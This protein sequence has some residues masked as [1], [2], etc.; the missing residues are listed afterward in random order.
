[1]PTDDSYFYV[2]IE[3]RRLN[4]M[5]TEGADAFIHDGT[6]PYHS[7]NI[8]QCITPA[9]AT[10]VVDQSSSRNETTTTSQRRQATEQLTQNYIMY[11]CLANSASTQVFERIPA[12]ELECLANHACNVFT[13]LTNNR[14]WIK[15]GV[16]QKVDKELLDCLIPHMKHLNFVTVA[17]V[18]ST[19]LLGVIADLCAAKTP[20]MPCPDFCDSILSITNNARLT[21]M[22]AGW[23]KERTFKKLE[24]TGILGQAIRCITCTQPS[25]PQD[26]I[27]GHLFILE[28][29][30]E[31]PMLIQEKFQKGT[32]SGDILNNVL[33]GKDGY[34]GGA[35]RHELVMARL[36]NI[37]KIAN[38][39]SHPP[40]QDALLVGLMCRKCNKN[41][42]EAEFQN[43][44]LVCG[45][46]KQT[47][48]CSK[49][50]KPKKNKVQNSRVK[51]SRLL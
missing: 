14:K 35:R 36:A 23:K 26:A 2:N 12:T 37:Q 29:L 46:C 49:G 41:S 15:T 22:I 27:Q 25:L 18:P 1:M 44:L 47:Y 3:G 6:R 30:M 10:L 28:V 16:L 13:Q 38:V 39:T 51:I 20:G 42:M 45:R 19:N 7:S 48:Y 50:K 17:L 5:T 21:L 43:K 31:C 40:N 8:A 9:R 33:S 34:K 32:R 4:I 11:G 24:S